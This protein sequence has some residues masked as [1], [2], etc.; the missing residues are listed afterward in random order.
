MGL[1]L[2]PGIQQGHLKCL[3]HTSK[4][5]LYCTGGMLQSSSTTAESTHAGFSRG[6]TTTNH[7]AST[8]LVYR[9]CE[10]YFSFHRM[11]GRNTTHC[12]WV[13]Q[14][15]RVKITVWGSTTVRLTVEPQTYALCVCFDCWTCWPAVAP[16]VIYY[17]VLK[18]YVV[19]PQS[20]ASFSS[21]F[22]DKQH[23]H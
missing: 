4:C 21:S 22:T 16:M 18:D 6:E 10:T 11:M 20:L 5:S 14:L 1:L 3:C 2:N 13:R 15:Q 23:A 8:K 7:L 9:Y 19:H 17:T 12:Q